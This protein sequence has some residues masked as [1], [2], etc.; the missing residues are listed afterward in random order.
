[1]FEDE[2]AVGARVDQDVRDRSGVVQV[3]VGS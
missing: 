3:E 2:A 1:M